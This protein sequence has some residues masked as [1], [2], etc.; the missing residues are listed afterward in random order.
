MTDNRGVSWSRSQAP[1]GVS[2]IFALFH[3]SRIV[4]LTAAV[5]ACGF[6]DLHPILRILVNFEQLFACRHVQHPTKFGCAAVGV[7]G[8][9]PTVSRH[10]PSVPGGQALAAPY[11]TRILDRSKEPSKRIFISQ[12]TVVGRMDTSLCP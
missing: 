12:A 7:R 2:S 1:L 6:V 11:H 3:F 9:H 8:T 4:L 5:W 10:R